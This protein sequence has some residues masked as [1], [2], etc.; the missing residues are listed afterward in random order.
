MHKVNNIL[1]N[2]VLGFVVAMAAAGCQLEKDGPSAERQ[3]VMIE[4]S[5]SAPE[6]TK[7]TPTDME[8][9]INSLRVYAF[10]GERLAGYALRQATTPG[11]PF[12]MDLELPETGKHSVTFYLIANEAEMTYQNATVT[13]TEDM[14]MAQLKAVKFSAMATGNALPMYCIH[15]ETVD[16]DA[17]AEAANDE[18]GHNGHF[19]LTQKVKFELTRPI[20]KVS[21]YAAKTEGA[22]VDPQILG[23]ELLAAGTRTFNYLFPQTEQTLNEIPS[24]ANDEVLLS[25]AVAVTSGIAKGSSALQ[26]PDNYTTVVTD[27]YLY[28]VAYGSDSWNVSSGNANEAVLHIAYSLGEGQPRKDAYVY[29]P[30][31]LRNKHIKVCIYINAEGQIIINYVVADW[32]DN[33]TQDI[34]FDYPTHSYLRES[35]PASQ[36]DLA[37]VPSAEAQMSEKKAFR[38]YFQMT[39]PENDSWTPTLIGLNASDCTVRVYDDTGKLEVPRSEWPIPASEDWY[40]IEVSPNVGH[41]Q[42][43]EEVMLAITYRAAGF[44]TVEYMMINGTDQ[45]FYWPYSGTSAQDADYVIITMVN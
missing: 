20:A 44:D 32:E 45:N 42:A 30:P 25:S 1:L 14:T 12:Y 23:I 26:D 37:T 3:S 28:E 27:K 24:R 41:I 2:I 10:Y 39:Y 31:V 43:G 5:V 9:V 34:R 18:A 7:A 29:L 40:T 33:E 35:I 16:V 11:E 4:L 8:Q 36:E 17:V 6:M 15:T 21:L 19:V 13:L 38:A 22:S